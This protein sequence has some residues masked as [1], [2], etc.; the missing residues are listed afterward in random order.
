MPNLIESTRNKCLTQGA[1]DLSQEDY[2]ALV[3]PGPSSQE[4]FRIHD[5]LFGGNLSRIPRNNIETGPY[6]APDEEPDV[7]YSDADLVGPDWEPCLG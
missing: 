7:A 4:I 1:N 6:S 2:E 5:L 3:R